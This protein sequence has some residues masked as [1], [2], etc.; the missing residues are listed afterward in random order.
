MNVQR[1]HREHGKHVRERD[2][3]QTF[4]HVYY[5]A[6]L[7]RASTKF[8][9]HRAFQMYTPEVIYDAFSLECAVLQVCSSATAASESDNRLRDPAARPLPYLRRLWSDTAIGF[10]V[11]SSSRRTREERVLRP[12]TSVFFAR[13]VKSEGRVILLS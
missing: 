7:L 2:C 13:P 3:A 4:E 1:R 11:R 10:A 8:L 12:A 5:Y 6:G 9:L